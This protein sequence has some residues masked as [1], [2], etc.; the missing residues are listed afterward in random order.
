MSR[1]AFTAVW[2]Q[3]SLP[4][5]ERRPPRPR[6]RR[7]L[8]LARAVM[9]IRATVPSAVVPPVEPISDPAALNGW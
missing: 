3:S 6:R 5:L 2:T 9:R 8:R 4:D 7:I 1:V